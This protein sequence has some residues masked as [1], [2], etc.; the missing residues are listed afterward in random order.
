MPTN[1]RQTH[2]FT[3]VGFAY[4]PLH[5]SQRTTGTLDMTKSQSFMSFAELS[6]QL[7]EIDDPR[8]VFDLCQTSLKLPDFKSNIIRIL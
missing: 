5:S 8:G 6:I 7:A 3:S 4:L 1:R 2:W